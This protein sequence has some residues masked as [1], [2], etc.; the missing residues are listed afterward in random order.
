[1]DEQAGNE[2]AMEEGHPESMEPKG[3]GMGG[4]GVCVG[5]RSGS[6]LGRVWGEL[7]VSWQAKINFFSL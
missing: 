6:S 5:A 1:M 7:D 3:V 2:F 4:S